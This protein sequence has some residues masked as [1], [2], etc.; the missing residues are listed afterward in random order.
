[1]VPQTIGA[2]ASFLALVAPGI[3]F[4]LL[5]EQRRAGPKETVFRE[6]SRV[7]LSSLAFTVAST[8]ILLGVHA[9]A[10]KWFGWKLFADLNAV[11]AKPDYVKQ[12]VA[13]LGYSAVAE[14]VLACLL[15][16]AFDAVLARRRRQPRSLGKQS[17]WVKV[18]REDRP[19]NAL[20]WVHVM[21]EDGSSFFGFL[22]SYDAA[23]DPDTREIVLEGT[24]LTYVGEPVTGGDEKKTTVIGRDWERVV[25]PG[26]RIRFMR[27]QYL[28]AE[29][30]TR[31][32]S[33]R[34]PV[35]ADAAP[36]K[37]VEQA[38]GPE[39]P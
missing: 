36:R 4:E 13:L 17:A 21:L 7:A 38:A 12:N 32:D 22:R 11:V 33:A 26:A 30:G 8:A 15:A 1:M 9:L 27:V 34:R 3:V 29:T 37:P 2:L 16:L 5:R 14:L 10:A 18:F 23:G 20:C 31:V 25:I 6:A 28:D 39:T 35:T 24:K 19:P